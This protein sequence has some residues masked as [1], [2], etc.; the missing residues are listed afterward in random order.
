MN[1][2]NNPINVLITGGAGFIGSALILKIISNNS[3][4]NIVVI[5]EQDPKKPISGVKYYHF[6]LASEN[7]PSEIYKF[8]FTYV[9]HL[10]AQT[11]GRISVEDPLLD[12]R[13]NIIGLINVCEFCKQNNVGKLIFTSSMA[14]YENSNKPLKET[15][16]LNPISN[17]GISKEA[18]EKYI[19]A[20]SK[21]NGFKYT[22]LRLFNV[23]GP[24]QDFTNMKQGML[25]I[26]IA[27]AIKYKKINVTG[28]FDRFRDFI[29]ISD[30]VDALIL[31]MD[32]HCNDDI[33][34]IGSGI[35]TT[36]RK[37]LQ[38]IND[39]IEED[40]IYEDIGGFM[41]DQ[42][43]TYACINKIERLGWSPTIPIKKGLKLTLESLEN[44]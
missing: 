12:A 20:Y 31:A 21:A 15:H 1:S 2:N 40:I 36:V 33:Y 41:Q 6:N 17:Y 37:L 25:S 44:V 39:A 3:R 19:K 13:S 16:Q 42:N 10:A 24:G 9:Y 29:Y 7:W 11:S 28:S 32:D 4:Y 30:V 22:T 35:K 14:V 23:Y 27:Q 38:M 34:N 18:G 43:G 8:N 5:D 26:F